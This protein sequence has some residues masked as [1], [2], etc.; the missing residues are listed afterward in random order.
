MTEIEKVISGI[1]HNLEL[2]KSCIPLFLSNPGLGKSTIIREF[3]E[4]IGKKC[5]TVIASTKMPHEFSGISIPNHDTKRMTYFDYDAL[6][7]LKDGDCLF[8]DE[9]LND[10]LGNLLPTF[11]LVER[12]MAFTPNKSLPNSNIFRQVSQAKTESELCLLRGFN[13]FGSTSS[14]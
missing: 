9:I 12:T 3:F 10:S 6:L 8:L 1:Y 13:F 14:R 11:S 7:D 4:N 2:R 5:L